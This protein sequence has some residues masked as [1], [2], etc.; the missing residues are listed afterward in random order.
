MTEA[1]WIREQDVVDL[2][3]LPAAIEALRE[4]LPDEASGTAATLLK[5]HVD[6]GEGALHA[7]GGAIPLAGI[8][9]TKSW[10][11]THN[12]ACPLLV[13]FDSA[14]GSLSAIIEAFALGQMRT[15]AMS[16]LAT[17]L[18]AVPD[19]KVLSLA[20]TGKQSLAQ[21]AAV[22]A[23][24]PIELIRVWSRTAANAH[25]FA[26]RVKDEFGVD[27]EVAATPTEA[28]SAADVITLATRAT[29][30][31]VTV[32]LP[33]RGA[34]INAIGAI[35]PERAEFEPDLLDRATI[36]AV[37]SVPH[38]REASSELRTYF[39]DHDE[40]WTRVQP[41]SQ[42]VA[43]STR[44]PHDA[45]LTVFKAMGLGLADVA[46]GARVLALAV[47]EGR[48]RPVPQPNHARPRLVHHQNNQR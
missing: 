20:G 17:D 27:T 22:L 36:V 35:T 16:G 40:G 14:D 33:R 32:A 43:R 1:L 5:R 44:R 19:A 47:A 26:A 24:R 18:L 23:V 28:L 13:L 21:V 3:D 15:S 31:F 2:V 37:D 41:L 39:G 45:D 38:A 48:G 12:G 6:W 9:G 10:V 7:L 29:I 46:I 42:L 34:H 11:H 25:A 30:P 4:L 8:A